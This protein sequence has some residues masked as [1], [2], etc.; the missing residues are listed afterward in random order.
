[1]GLQTSHLEHLLT[2]RVMQIGCLLWD[3]V[4]I[5]EQVLL[6]VIIDP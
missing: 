1:M 2:V 4:L 6:H 3:L 5:I